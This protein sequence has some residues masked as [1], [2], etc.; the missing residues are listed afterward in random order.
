[1]LEVR[2]IRKTRREIGKFIRFAWQIYRDDPNFVPPL[3]SDQLKAL[4]GVHNALFDNGEQAFLMAYKDNRPVARVLVGINEQLNHVKGYTQGYLSLFECENDQATADALLGAAE[5]WLRIRGMNR[6]VGPENYTY[7]DFGK[8][9]L[10]EGFDGPPVL[11]NP[12]NP[13]YYNELFVRHGF[14]KQCDHFAFYLRVGDFKPDKYEKICDYARKKI[15]YRVD[16]VDLDGHFEREVKD[17]AYV[18]S[19]GMPE[20]LEQLAP[21]TENDVREEA[22]M[23]KALADQDMV[24]IARLGNRP[25]GFLLAMPDYNQIIGRMNGRMVSPAALSLLKERRRAQGKKVS[26]KVVDGIRVIVM[27]VIPEYQNTAVTGAMMLELYHAALR[28]GYTWGEASTIDERNVY[29]LNSAIKTGAKIYR[30]YR[31]YEKMI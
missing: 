17:I 9:M 12:Y 23:L 2:E 20:L 28:K 27:F 16:R 10:A 8:G 13:A 6:V 25:I 5:E 19:T 26:G 24:Y 30:T 4:M 22:K 3:I 11:F 7:D 1:M 31:V 21:P 18:L 29:S 15:G 14:E